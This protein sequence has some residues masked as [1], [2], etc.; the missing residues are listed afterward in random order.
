MSYDIDIII[1]AS[2][3]A[4]NLVA[5]FY[6]GRGIKTIKEYAIGNRNFS[7]ATLA[8]TIIATW[9]GG[10]DFAIS[11]SE[12]YRNGLWYVVAGTGYAFNLMVVSYIFSLQ[13]QCFDGSISVAETM[14][15]LYGKSV[16][17]ITA[18]ASIASCVAVIAMQIKV[19]ST[20]F[21]HFLGV[22]SIY[23]TLASSFVVI[24]YSA[25]GGIK[26]VTFTDIIQFITFGVV[27]PI[28]A[29]FVWQVLGNAESIENTLTNPLFDYNELIKFNPDKSYA[30]LS[31]FLCGLIPA[32]N[33]VMFQRM[34]MAKSISQIR[35]SFFI[36][37]FVCLSIYT[38]TCFIGFI[39]FTHNPNLEANNLAMYVIDNYSVSGIKSIAIIGIMAMIMSTADSYI[40]TSSIIFSH[41]LCKPLG[42][43]AKNELF[44]SRA[45]AIFIGISA[46]LL[47]LS[48]DHLLELLFLSENFYMP[49]VTIPLMLSIFGFRSNTRFVLISM[50]F[51][52]AMVIIWKSYIQ[53]ST[54][55]ES[56]IPA[57]VTNLLTLLLL[58]YFSKKPIVRVKQKQNSVKK[59]AKWRSFK[60]YILQIYSS[61][62]INYCRN[63]TPK[64]EMIYTYFAFSVMMTIITTLSLDKSIYNQHIILVNVLQGSSLFIST[65]FICHKLWFPSFKEKYIGLIFFISVFLGLSFVSSFLAFISKFSQISLVIFILNLTIIGILMSWQTTLIMILSGLSLSFFSYQFYMGN[66]PNIAEELYSLKLQIIYILFVISGFLLAFLKPKQEQYELTEQK[67]YHL[68]EQIY[69]REEELEKLIE[70]KNEFLRNLEHEAH[71]PIV[72]IASMG[73]IL[74]ESYDKL[75]DNQRRKGLEE[76]AKSSERLSSLVN[77]MIDLSK[78]LSLNYTLDKKELNLSELVYDRLDYCKKLYLNGKEL[79][80]FT[81]IEDN[82]KVNCDEH[83]IK[84]TLDNLIINAIQYSKEGNITLEL[85]KNSDS[86]AIDFSIRDEGIAIPQAELY[87]IFLSFIVSSRTKT[88]AGGRGI[89]LALCKKAISAHGGQ[90]WAESDGA[91]GSTFRFTLPMKLN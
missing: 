3:L 31:I 79:Q 87:D 54:G 17:I 10:S 46:V 91:K 2:F 4:I 60:K 53:P 69:D 78:L 38:M 7:T 71:T 37:S 44:L 80:F 27:I 65:I 81:K 19:F 14:G 74:F 58:H 49:I 63:N 52:V 35:K 61:N 28:F 21:S 9:I 50:F 66:T 24:V 43:K 42:I 32:L 47:T 34:L 33:P 85:H 59:K 51:G 6:S 16:R 11:L 67:A 48:A 88:L 25:F 55:I 45:F 73:Q 15:K 90:I 39:V 29:M 20:I 41:D 26:A 22:S 75:T 23:A 36:S 64:N 86:T 13:A 83:Y 18:I 76:I 70:V 40:N 68:G 30:Y 5:G 62:I 8:A 84:S 1:I 77:N 89:G 12:T 57:M 72:G 82:I 56:V